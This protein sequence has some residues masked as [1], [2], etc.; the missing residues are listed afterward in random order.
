MQPKVIAIHALAQTGLPPRGL[1]HAQAAAYIG[2]SEST[3]DNM[4]ADGTMPPAKRLK[5]RRVWDRHQLDRAFAAIPD[6]R[7]NVDAVDVWDRAAV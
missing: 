3:F 2:V 7:G 1:S 5:G 6:E 4:I